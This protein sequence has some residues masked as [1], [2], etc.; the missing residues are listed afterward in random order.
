MQVLN[1]FANCCPSE[2]VVVKDHNAAAWKASQFI[3]KNKTKVT[4]WKNLRPLKSAARTL[5]DT[6]KSTTTKSTTTKT[7]KIKNVKAT[8]DTK[9]KRNQ[10]IGKRR[11]NAVPRHA[12]ET[13]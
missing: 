5:A 10:A 4:M 2:L 6:N 8:S 9:T 13:C 3:D 7:K 12:N 1:I 11:Q